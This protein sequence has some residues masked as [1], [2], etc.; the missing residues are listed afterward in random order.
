MSTDCYAITSYYNPARFKRRL[1]NYKRFRERLGVP[2][3][4]VEMSSTGE[5]EL[6]GNDADILV[7]IR[8]GACLWQKERLLNVAIDHLP[9]SAEFVVWTDCDVIFECEDWPRTLPEALEATPLVQCYS[10][11]IYLQDC[12][13]PLQRSPDSV[14]DA[15]SIASKTAPGP[16]LASDAM[17]RT[18]ARGFRPGLAWAARREL[19]ARHGLYDVLIVGGGDRALASAALGR[20][21]E[22]ISA[23][24]MN[25]TRA[26]HYLKWAKPFYGDV[27]GGVGA[28]PGRALHLWHGN[29][30]DRHYVERH[31]SLAGFG[32]DPERHLVL[33]SH[34][35]WEWSASAPQ[36]LKEFL[37]TYF[38]S[39]FE[40]G[41]PAVH[42]SARE[43][44]E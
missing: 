41:R 11:V 15:Y 31:M 34:G 8:G 39:R 12:A 9:R 42:S 2:L 1:I 30:D 25:S 24:R 10:E 7:Q 22:A 4:T 32:F 35:A 18:S 19:I 16:N 13:R 20:F 3:V 26:D 21:D 38:Q 43:A 29:L 28:L 44:A 5:F 40:D 27:G 36:G 14:A 37:E 17:P 33:G 6:S 23:L